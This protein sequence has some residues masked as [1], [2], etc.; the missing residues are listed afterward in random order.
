M[1]A[2]RHA[3]HVSPV[4]VVVVVLALQL[5]RSDHQTYSP[6]IVLLADQTLGNRGREERDKG[7]MPPWSW[8]IHFLHFSKL[9][10][11]LTQLVL[12]MAN[13]T[14]F[15]KRKMKKGTPV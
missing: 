12:N 11:M 14:I 5:L 9:L 2:W 13:V 15:Y 6:K 7:K 10:E 3:T 8:D 4:P 1:H